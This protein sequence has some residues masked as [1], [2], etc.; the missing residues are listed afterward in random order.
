MVQARL[1]GLDPEARRVL[2]AASVF[3]W[4]FWTSGVLA[5]LGGEDQAARVDPWLGALEAQ[6]VVT[7]RLEARFGGEAERAFRHALV[8]E[9]TSAMLTEEDQRLGHGLASSK[10]LRAYALSALETARA[11]L[12][13]R[14]SRISDP[15]QRRSFLQNVPENARTLDN[16][17]PDL[18]S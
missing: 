3:G 8:G 17:G 6:E 10:P 11:R 7:R 1:E 5:L 18:K 2:R 13:D 15:E 16:L 12:L 14:A 9:A 4:V